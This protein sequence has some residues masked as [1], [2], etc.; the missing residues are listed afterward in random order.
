[1]K[2]FCQSFFDLFKLN[3]NSLLKRRLCSKWRK[4]GKSMLRSKGSSSLFNLHLK[5]EYKI[6]KISGKLQALSLM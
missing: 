4:Q 3:A 5:E 1:M 2:L 6:K